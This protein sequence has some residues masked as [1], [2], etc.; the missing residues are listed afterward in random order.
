[1]ISRQWSCAWPADGKNKGQCRKQKGRSFLIGLFC[2]PRLVQQGRYGSNIW[3]GRQDLNLRPLAPHA[4]ALPSCATPRRPPFG[5]AAIIPKTASVSSANAGKIRGIW[6]FL[7]VGRSRRRS[8]CRAQRSSV[9]T[10][11]SSLIMSCRTTLKMPSPGSARDSAD[12]AG[13][14]SSSRSGWRVSVSCRRAPPMV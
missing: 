7:A 1:M 4:S 10:C 6:G 12:C 8:G 9:A 5:E 3:S 11:S 2:E 14:S 13:I